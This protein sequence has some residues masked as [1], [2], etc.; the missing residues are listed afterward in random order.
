MKYIKPLGKGDFLMEKTTSNHKSILNFCEEALGH[1]IA[2]LIEGDGGF[3]KTFSLVISF[4]LKDQGLAEN[5]IKVLE[6]GYL[7]KVPKFDCVKLYITGQ[8]G[9]RRILD[10]TNGK[11]VGPF[12]I[13]QLL[14]H[15]YDKHLNIL[16]LPATNLV[17]FNNFWLTGFFDADGY[18]SIEI[19]NTKEQLLKKSVRVCFCWTQKNGL[20]LDLIAD[21]FA[22]LFAKHTIVTK[23]SSKQTVNRPSYTWH[24]FKITSKTQLLVLFDYFDKFHP[25][26]TKY[27]QILLAWQCYQLMLKNKH[28]TMEGLNFIQGLL[29]QSQTITTIDFSLLD[30]QTFLSIME[31]TPSLNKVLRPTYCSLTLKTFDLIDEALEKNKPNYTKIAQEFAISRHFLARYRKR[32]EYYR[33]RAAIIAQFNQDG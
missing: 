10:L 18:I 31:G 3:Y 26:G 20:L 11:F 7:Y 13:G 16:I 33:A 17:S 4:H 32:P 22:D 6:F 1:Y 5:L 24:R 27:Q 14:R 2:G 30:D 12:K 29:T 19:A 25:Q 21:L 9:L 8:D 28:L 15:G 23:Q